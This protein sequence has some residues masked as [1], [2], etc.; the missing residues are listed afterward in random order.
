[1]NSAMQE[2]CLFVRVGGLQGLCETMGRTATT[3]ALDRLDEAL[4]PMLDG[5]LGHPRIRVLPTA[6]EQGPGQWVRVFSCSAG[7]GLLHDLGLAHT[8]LAALDGGL[9]ELACTVFGPATARMAQ[10]EAALLPA[11]A[12]HGV[13]DAFAVRSTG[14]PGMSADD[15]RSLR[16]L[17]DGS[18]PRVFLQP[19]VR[20]VDG[21]LIGFE[22]LARGPA[23]ST[24]ERADR[25]FGTARCCGLE[26]ALEIACIHAALAWREHIP[27]GL[28]LSINVSARTLVM[29][30]VE[31][32]LARPGI[33]VELTEHLPLGRACELVPVLTRLRQAG[34]RL[35][36]DDTGCGFADLQAA[37]AMRPDIVKLCITIVNALDRQP[38]LLAELRA[39]VDTLR[40]LGCEIL[41]EGI[42]TRELA[43][44]LAGLGIEHGQGW[45]YGRP[46]A[47]EP[48]LERY[49]ATAGF[50][51]ADA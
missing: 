16:D 36:L 19:L 17:L 14:L 4:V 47:A 6:A 27:A 10:L 1:M 44:L 23:G 22:A 20:L 42:E 50:Q 28:L 8:I 26:P 33:L 2:H 7:D 49:R 30:G 41:A 40:G 11:A 3:V 9:A 21:G 12:P 5:L 25:L 13:A 45:F 46:E 43:E 34:A 18:G 24:L 38:A 37:Q 31:S 48:M 35:A 39:V 15:E 51:S 32:L 29:P